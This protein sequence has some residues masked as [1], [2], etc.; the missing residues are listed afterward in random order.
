MSIF[1][2]RHA[3]TAGNAA[4]I[5]Q[6]PD[7][8]LTDRGHVQ[9]ERLAERLARV[10]IRVILTSDLARAA[11]TAE[12]LSRSTGL[13]VRYESLLHERN[14]GDLRGTPYAELTVDPFA[15]GYAPPNGETWDAFHAR[16]DRAWAR[17]QD[18]AA[19]TDGHL[20]VV[21]HGLVCRSLAS[22]HLTLPDGHVVP[23]RWENASLT[24]ID[25][26][27]PWRVELL[28]CCAHLDGLRS[29]TPTGLV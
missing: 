5:L 11:M 29:T 13:R 24:I 2:I 26:Q 4:R 15:E 10:G 22:R 1:L 14:F 21:T 6:R 3:E 20:A 19:S 25:G 8:P 7:I 23:E 12:H 27:A 17:V 9:A 16:V 18:V 28:H